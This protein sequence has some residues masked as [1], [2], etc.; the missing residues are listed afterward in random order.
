QDGAAAARRLGRGLEHGGRV[1]PG[2]APLRLLLRAPLDAP[3]RP[4]APDDPARRGAAPRLR[5]LADRRRFRL[6]AAQRGPAD[7]VADRAARGLDRPALLRG[8]GHRAAL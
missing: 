5:G 2:D 8:L 6:D 7:P 1:L 3:A 4:A